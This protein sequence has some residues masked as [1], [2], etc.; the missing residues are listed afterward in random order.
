MDDD[1]IRARILS[2]ADR[3]GYYCPNDTSVEGLADH[4]V[5]PSDEGRAKELIHEL[6]RSDAEPLQYRRRNKT[7]CL[8]VDSQRW[9]AARIAHYDSDVLEWSQRQRLNG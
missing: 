2:T 7:V 3:G 8:D 4:A 1:T 6:A 9:T 5:G